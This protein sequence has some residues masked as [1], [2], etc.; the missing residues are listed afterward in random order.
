MTFLAGWAQIT[1]D[2]D[3]ED[4]A[5][6]QRQIDARDRTIADLRGQLAALRGQLAER[7][8]L[9]PRFRERVTESSRPP[10]QLPLLA[11]EAMP[12]Y[13]QPAP[14]RPAPRR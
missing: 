10:E 1:L 8:A 2:A 5:D 6:K 11:A 9:T 4:I 14:G 3:A 13:R 12:T 7:T